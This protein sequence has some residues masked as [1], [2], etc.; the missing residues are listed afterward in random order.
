MTAWHILDGPLAP[1]VD[2]LFVRFATVVSGVALAL[3]GGVAQA[4]VDVRVSGERKLDVHATAARLS[5]VLAEV[6]RRAGMKLIYDG[7]PPRQ[8]VSVDFTGRSE[9][10]AVVALLEG[11]G[12]SYAMMLDHSGNRVET[13]VV[14]GTAA[15]SSGR[16]GVASPATTTGS[17]LPS[18]AEQQ[19]MEEGRMPIPPPRDPPP[20][21][22]PSAGAEMAPP[23]DQEAPPE[24]AS[25]APNVARPLMPP[26]PREGPT[27]EPA[28]PQP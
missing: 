16:P 22:R 14:I 2:C 10:A 18:F 3:A 1:V 6:S 13:L 8:I 21:E 20:P 23:A 25:T 5:D 7:P 28:K 24:T 15:V 27:K 26:V 11:L 9:P 12:L 19:A 17:D 4:A